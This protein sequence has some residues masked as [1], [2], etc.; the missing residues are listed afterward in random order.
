M[1]QR[2]HEYTRKIFLAQ[3]AAFVFV[4]A[5][6][7]VWP[8]GW[9][10]SA[11]IKRDFRF[12]LFTSSAL[13]AII[14]KQQ[15]WR[16][17]FATQCYQVWGFTLSNPREFAITVEEEELSTCSQISI[18]IPRPCILSNIL[19]SFCP[20]AIVCINAYGRYKYRL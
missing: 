3:V 17:G 1:R 12:W 16:H 8:S 7:Y 18:N 4:F 6:I 15:P 2:L 11:T 20:I 9:A 13:L 10:T 14:S 19:F 5:S